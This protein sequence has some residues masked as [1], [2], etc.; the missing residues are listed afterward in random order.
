[1]VRGKHKHQNHMAINILPDE[2]HSIHDEQAGQA[3]SLGKWFRAGKSIAGEATREILHLPEKYHVA[4]LEPHD[5]EG[6]LRAQQFVAKKYLELGKVE[7]TDIDPETRVIKLDKDD[8]S[9]VYFVAHDSASKELVMVTTLFW[10]KDITIDDLPFPLEQLSD[11]TVTHLRSL[12]PGSIADL[13]RETKRDRK[14]ED[15]VSIKL[16]REVF[17]Y[18][19]DNNINTLVCG[20]QPRVFEKYRRIFGHALQKL[21]NQTVEFT[22]FKGPQVPLA[23]DVPN[24]YRNQKKGTRQ[25]LEPV[26]DEMM[27]GE[28]VVPARSVSLG[29][30]AL[31]WAV[32]NYF[33][34]DRPEFKR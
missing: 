13:G 30:V 10:H 20:L 25:E 33:A 16:L 23:I 12:T 2:R 3:S 27:S 21:S 15:V 14:V 9:T 1:M 19:L 11:E 22:G 29:D 31:R 8:P 17:R 5:D 4:I 32:R 28:F 26:T 18:C 34:K 6:R 24:C 7:E